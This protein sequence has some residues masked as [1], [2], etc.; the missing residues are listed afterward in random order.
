M[1]DRAVHGG[2]KAQVR[3]GSKADLARLKGDFRYTPESGRCL[4]KRPCPKGANNGTRTNS[5]NKRQPEGGSQFKPDDRGLGSNQCSTSADTSTLSVRSACTGSAPINGSIR[6]L[7][8]PTVRFA[9]DAQSAPLPLGCPK[10][11]RPIGPWRAIPRSWST[12]LVSSRPSY[13]STN[14]CKTWAIFGCLW[15]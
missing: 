6:G 1:W 3:L 8:S 5:P 10:C 12:H 15:R 13:C 14:K 7:A 11:S 9:R 4:T 2:D